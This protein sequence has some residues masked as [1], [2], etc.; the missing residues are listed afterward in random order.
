MPR[1]RRLPSARV[2]SPFDATTKAM[3]KLLD[4]D[5]PPLRLGLGNTILS[6][7]RAACSRRQLPQSVREAQGDSLEHV[8]QHVVIEGAVKL[9]FL[10][11][12]SLRALVEH[13]RGGVPVHR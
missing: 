8:D 5:D 3:L 10:G 7:V 4:T 1:Y 9:R 12:R 2:G 13:D 6:G 11:Q